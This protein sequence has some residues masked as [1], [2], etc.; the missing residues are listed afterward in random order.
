MRFSPGCSCCEELPDACEYC[1]TGTTPTTW[2]VEIDGLVNDDC[3]NCSN[4]NRSY[5][6]SQTEQC[7]WESAE[8]DYGCEVNPFYPGKV[9]VR[10]AVAGPSQL[11]VEFR[12]HEQYVFY[13]KNMGG[14]FDCELS[15]ENVPLDES[16]YDTICDASNSTC[17]LTGNAPFG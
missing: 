10:L 11:E 5:T 12:L 4:Y 2:T 7:Q 9:I 15:A 16:L 14:T 6:C 17:A 13:R 8:F 3:S 1:D